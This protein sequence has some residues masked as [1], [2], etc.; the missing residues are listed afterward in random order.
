MNVP[1]ASASVIRQERAARCSRIWFDEILLGELRSGKVKMAV[2]Q[3][4]GCRNHNAWSRIPFGEELP[5]HQLERPFAGC[6]LE[7]PFTSAGV[8]SVQKGLV[9]DELDGPAALRGR[10]LS[11]AMAFNPFLE[12]GR[13]A[14]VELAVC[15]EE[16]VNV[17]QGI[18]SET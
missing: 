3:P 13:V 9:E 12:I 2:M 5:Q 4:D 14:R 11:F 16:H 6:L 7:V 18:D 8:T 1:P 17:I 10:D 15:T